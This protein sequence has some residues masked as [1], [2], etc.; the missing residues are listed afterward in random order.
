MLYNFMN[1]QNLFSVSL[2]T[3]NCVAHECHLNIIYRIAQKRVHFHYNVYLFVYS[4]KVE[5]AAIMKNCSNE[6]DIIIK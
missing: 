4:R 3:K 5:R 2:Y 1:S 6:H